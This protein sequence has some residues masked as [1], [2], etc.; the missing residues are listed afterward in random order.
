MDAQGSV[1]ADVELSLFDEVAEALRGM[2]A[3]SWGPIR[4]R[5]RAYGIKAWFGA[6]TPSREHY[7]AQVISPHAV[8][9]AQVLGLEIGFHAEHPHVGDNE[10][11]LERLLD[12]EKRWRKRLGADAVAGPFLGRAD[13]WRRVSE[14]WSDPDLDE[15]GLGMEIAGRLADYVDALEPVLRATPKSR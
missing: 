2:V 4:C 12:S 5:P 14:T 10:R 11:V 1:A 15:A 9:G 7:E 13:V 3:S 6:T 8:G